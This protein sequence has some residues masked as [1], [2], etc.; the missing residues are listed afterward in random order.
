MTEDEAKQRWCPFSRVASSTG[1]SG[2]MTAES[3]VPVNRSVGRGRA[4]EV[5][6]LGSDCMAWRWI[7]E[8]TPDGRGIRTS[9]TEGYCG[10]AG[11]P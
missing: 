7:V 2:G 4:A 8:D 1:Q 3:F 9:T 10:L 11:R 6:C 5:L